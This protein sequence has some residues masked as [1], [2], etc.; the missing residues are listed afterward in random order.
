MRTPKFLIIV[1]LVFFISSCIVVSFHPLYTEEDLF[2]NNL[3]LGEWIDQDSSVWQFR[4]AYKGDVLSENTDSTAYI[5]QLKE[6]GKAD[7]DHSSFKVHV[8][9]LDGQYFLDFFLEDYRK[10]ESNN[11]DLFDLHVLPVHSF[12]RLDLSQGRGE[13]R[14]FN[15]DWLKKLAQSGELDIR[16]ETEDGNYLLT[17]PTSDLQKFVVK[18]SRTEAAY[19]DGVK[20]ELRRMN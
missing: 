20:S 12:A 8:L 6:K 4:Y 14:W 18:Y 10:N 5:L 11:P 16:H 9:R 1:L 7:F 19:T 3:L 13:I 15:P 2:A 17:A